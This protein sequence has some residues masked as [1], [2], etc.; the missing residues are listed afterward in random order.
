MSAASRDSRPAATVRR[1]VR[2]GAL[3]AAAALALAACGAGG[4]SGGSGNTNFVTSKDGISTVKSAD[5]K[6]GPEISGKTLQGKP[7]DLADLRGKL[8][9]LNV[10]GSW[11]PPCRAEAPGFV[12][13]AKATEPKGVEFVGLNTRDTGTGPAKR[14]EENFGVPY[15]SLYDPA[16]RLM[17]RFPKGTLNPQAIPSTLVLDRKGRVA[18]RSLQPL[19]GEDLQKMLDPLIAEK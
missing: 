7:L 13:V 19:S 14:F 6:P 12:K 5:R 11:C 18:A 10:W 16:G 17:L 4:T 2:L 3:T 9:V 8:V 1:A 15:P